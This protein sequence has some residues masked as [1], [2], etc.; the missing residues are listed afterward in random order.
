MITY[1]FFFHVRIFCITLFNFGRTFNP[2]KPPLPTVQV[3]PSKVIMYVFSRLVESSQKTHSCLERLKLLF[4][5]LEVFVIWSVNE[6]PSQSVSCS[7]FHVFHHFLLGGL[8]LVQICWLSIL[9]Y[10]KELDVI[11]LS[12]VFVDYQRCCNY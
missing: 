8:P 4:W 10:F 12:Y 7:L 3:T 2:W 9:Y 1:M 5:I 6:E 11:I